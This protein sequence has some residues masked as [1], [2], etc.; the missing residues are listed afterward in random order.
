[1]EM[2]DS[3]DVFKELSCHQEL[4]IFAVK[5]PEFRSNRSKSQISC[6]ENY[7][8]YNEIFGFRDFAG[9]VYYSRYW[10]R[11]LP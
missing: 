7:R 2:V 3:I 6:H 8:Y 1:M 11:A 5:K 10:K 4:K 9:K